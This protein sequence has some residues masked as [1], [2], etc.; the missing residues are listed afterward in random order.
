[1]RITNPTKMAAYFSFTFTREVGEPVSQ[2]IFLVRHVI[3]A[4]INNKY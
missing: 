1:M 2:K 3:N 4:I